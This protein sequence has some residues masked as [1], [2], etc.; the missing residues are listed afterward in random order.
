MAPLTIYMLKRE[1]GGPIDIYKLLTSETSART[2]VK[3]V[4][5]KV[6]HVVRAV[7]LPAGYSRAAMPSQPTRG[8]RGARDITTRDFIVDR[9]D[10][11]G[12]TSLSS[13]DWLVYNGAKYQ[14][15]EVE[16]TDLS[17]WLI[18]ATELIGEVPQQT[19]TAQTDDRV[20]MGDNAI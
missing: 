6:Y 16:S 19:I 14:V 18:S 13:D 3:A 17:A 7:I 15:K 10:V 1:F 12:L 5:T 9:K 2:G 4:T 20:W 11:K 8:T